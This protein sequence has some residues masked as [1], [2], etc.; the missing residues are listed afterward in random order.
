MRTSFISHQIHAIISILTT[1]LVIYLLIYRKREEIDS[2]ELANLLLLLSVSWG[3][4]TLVHFYE[5]KVY[6]FD[7]LAGKW[8]VNNEPVK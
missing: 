4:H 6:N 5:E 8:K 7:P 2:Y 3:I 1:I